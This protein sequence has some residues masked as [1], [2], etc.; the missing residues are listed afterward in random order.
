[1]KK[2]YPEATPE[3][4]EENIFLEGAAETNEAIYEELRKQV[5]KNYKD[6]GVDEKL[7]EQFVIHNN[8]VEELV[9]KFSDE[10]KF[11]DKEKEIAV[12]ASILHDIAKGYGDFLKHGEEGG[13]MAEKLLLEKGVSEALARSVRLAIERHMGRDGYPSQMAKKEYG[14]DFEYPKYATKVGQLLYECD[15]MTQLTPEG[16]GKI[17][18]LRKTDRNNIEE[19]AKT[20]QEKNITIEQARIL[21]VLESA[22]K[23]FDLIEPDSAIKKHAQELWEGIQEKYKL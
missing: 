18:L 16:F 3:N 7:I 23:S 5:E 9:R 10:E 13:K 22:K 4:L 6:N 12:L 19:D 15:I 11:S 21:S 2:E 1:M 14:P 8:Q 20:A 17:L